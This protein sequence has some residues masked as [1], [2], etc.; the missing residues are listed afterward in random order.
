MKLIM[1]EPKSVVLDD[2][3][4]NSKTNSNSGSLIPDN[5]YESKSASIF[6]DDFQ[7]IEFPKKEKYNQYYLDAAYSSLPG[8]V[9]NHDGDG[10]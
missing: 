5:F 3:F 10:D 8:N 6:D 2:S 9:F 1:D 7:G 4:S